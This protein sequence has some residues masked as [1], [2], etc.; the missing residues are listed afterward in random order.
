MSECDS[1]KGRRTGWNS[2]RG[3]GGNSN[4]IQTTTEG[5]P[6]KLKGTGEEIRNISKRVRRHEWDEL[7]KGKSG[8][9]GK[10]ETKEEHQKKGV[11]K[12]RFF[13]T[14]QG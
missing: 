4:S 9:R 1:K 7:T 14:A 12:R 6:Y 3:G 2:L 13:E 10:T 11:A 8:E 5:G